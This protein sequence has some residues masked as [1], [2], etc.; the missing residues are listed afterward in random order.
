MLELL[1]LSFS[2]AR[3]EW[4]PTGKY[5]WSINLT[6]WANGINFQI[7]HVSSQPRMIMAILSLVGTFS[8]IFSSACATS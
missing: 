3:L 5:H 2:T 6:R 4:D 1:T 8:M 7:F